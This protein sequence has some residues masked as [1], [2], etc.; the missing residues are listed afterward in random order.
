MPPI[1][2]D[3]PE[4]ALCLCDP[5]CCC[6][7]ELPL[8]CLCFATPVPPLHQRPICVL[9]DSIITS[10]SRSAPSL[11]S[12]LETSYL[13]ANPP[14]ALLLSSPPHHLYFPQPALHATS[15][16]TN[17]PH[18]PL[19]GP[20]QSLFKFPNTILAPIT[21]PLALVYNFPSPHFACR[22]HN[23]FVAPWALALARQAAA[24]LSLHGSVLLCS[25]G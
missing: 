8:S 7:G 2:P 1:C 21:S 6:L 13:P 25:P 4:S 3:G 19:P 17:N 20:F 12:P 16:F 5:E 15:C 10:A 14:F 9:H 18:T 23:T 24:L 11:L 22:P